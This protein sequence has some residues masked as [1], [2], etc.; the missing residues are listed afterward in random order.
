MTLE[1]KRKLFMLTAN[2]HTEEGLR[3]FKAFAASLTGPIL[4]KVEEISYM[5]EMFQVDRLGPMDDASYPVAEEFDSPI[6][7]LPGMGYVAQDY[8][9]ML[10]EE[11]RI[12][13]FLVQAAKDWLLK[14]AKAGRLDVVTKAQQAVAKSLASYEEEAGWRVVVPACTAAFDGASV[15]PPRPAPIYQMTP[16][17]QA[18]GYFSKE[19]LN[20]MLVGAQRL[21]KN[22]HELWIS[23]EDMADIREYTDVDVD[24]TTRREIFQAA[25][26]SQIWGIRFRVIESIGVRGHYNINDRTSQFGPFKGDP[27]T[28]RFNDYSITHG[29]V[30]DENGGLVTSGETQ[31]YGFDRSDISLVMPIKQE[32]QAWDDPNLHRRQKQ[33]FYGWAEFG[34]AC[35]DPRFLFMGVIDRYT[36]AV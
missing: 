14:Y 25:G 27:S 36:P 30:L 18:A 1:E 20:R 21:G 32:F 35:L 29:N 11:V 33:G 12:P 10:A 17:D 16:G 26:L 22:I 34:M 6:W 3:A 5:R 9:E 8:I 4:K 19:L 24:P 15:L 7:I 31:V 2:M 13:T 28:N 23:P